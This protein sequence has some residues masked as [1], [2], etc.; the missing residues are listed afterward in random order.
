M[1]Q[2]GSVHSM[3]VGVDMWPGTLCGQDASCPDLPTPLRTGF[4]V[5]V[6]PWKAFEPGVGKL[7]PMEFC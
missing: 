1:D 2:P 3:S 7:E 4:L 5:G 6:E